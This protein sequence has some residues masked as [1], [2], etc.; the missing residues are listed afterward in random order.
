MSY[1]TSIKVRFGD[2]DHAGIAYY[3]N[4]YHYLHIAFEE[5]FEE[6]IG[7]P[8]PQVLDRDGIGFP[9]VAVSTEFLK[10]IRYGDTLSIRIA[11]RRV[12][13]SSVEMEFD[14]RRQGDASPCFLSRH[15]VVAV[16]IR[17]LRPVAIP[18]KYRDLFARC[19]AP[20]G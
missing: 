13:R 11:T 15:K 1:T 5:F 14:A 3:P 18:E 19:V 2:I 4:L 17:T 16:D 9:T 10:P 12:G 20:Q 6:Y 8:Y 7:T